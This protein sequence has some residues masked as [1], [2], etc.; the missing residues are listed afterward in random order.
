[1][2][3][4]P[5]GAGAEDLIIIPVSG[6]ATGGAG[7]IASIASVAV[8]ADVVGATCRITGST[9]NQIS[10]HDGNDLLI[11]TGGQTFV[12]PN[13]EDAGF[14]VHEAG[15]TAAVGSTIEL[16]IRF[17][18]DGLS[19]GGFRVSVDC[20]ATEGS[21]TT[22]APSTS[23]T[24]GE[25]TTTTEEPPAGPTIPAPTTVVPTTVVPTTELPAATAPPTTATPPSTDVEANPPSTSEQP[26]TTPTTVAPT[27]VVPTTETPP[28][29]PSA[30]GDGSLPVTGSP[31]GL[32]VTVGMA[33]VVSGM[34]LRRVGSA[35][36]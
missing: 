10:V 7:E 2:L 30:E 27:T 19:S 31:T 3:T 12:I 33:F 23:T 15:E 13:F 16:R 24:V 20:E 14:I 26:P 17:G 35:T 11:V 36:A 9:V 21:P 25:S 18:P 6:F 5:A 34:V 22:A 28:A 32:I 8:P 4:H 1:M 29:G